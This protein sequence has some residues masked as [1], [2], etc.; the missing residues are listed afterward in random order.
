MNLQKRN[1]NY[2]LSIIAPV[3]N[4]EGGI[5]K[6]RETIVSVLEKAGINFEILFINDGSK[7]DSPLIL[8]KMAQEDN[9]L[10]VINFSR[11]FGH[12]LAVS[13]GFDYAKGDA[14]VV[15]DADLQDPPQVITGLTEKWLEGYDIVNA[16]RRSRKD[17]FIKRM[18]ARLFYK[19]L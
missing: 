11:N 6:F 8:G 19:V 1:N 7:D 16:V 4:E 2:L 10:K 15:I 12:Q 13:A 3:Y 14:V 17:S 5:Q 9:R 18:T